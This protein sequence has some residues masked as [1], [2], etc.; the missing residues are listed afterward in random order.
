MSSPLSSVDDIIVPE[1]AERICLAR[2]AYRLW[3]LDTA[4]RSFPYHL[5]NEK[6]FEM[7]LRWEIG[8]V[9]ELEDFRYVMADACMLGLMTTE[10]SKEIAKR[11]AWVDILSTFPP[12]I[13]WNKI[14]RGKDDSPPPVPCLPWMF[15]YA[16]NYLS[17]LLHWW[18]EPETDVGKP[19]WWFQPV[20]EKWLYAVR[21]PRDLLGR[22]VGAISD[23]A[24]VLSRARVILAHVV[25]GE[26]VDV[27]ALNF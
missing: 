23:S 22:Y 26:S 7:T 12:V 24:E 15:G 8:L 14:P 11:L 1:T 17:T 16:S 3:R 21:V 13:R 4:A 9:L 20:K 6:L 5:E 27:E 19:A 25:A 10:L 2:F 18:E